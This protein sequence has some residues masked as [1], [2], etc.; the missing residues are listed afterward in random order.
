MDSNSL[1]WFYSYLQDR[2]QRVLINNSFSSLCNVSD[3]VSQGSVLS[4]L[5]F[6]LY[7]NDIAEKLIAPTSI[8]AYDTSFNYSNRDEL[9]IKPVIDHDMKELDEWSKIWLMYFNPD[10]TDIMIFQNSILLLMEELFLFQILT[11][12]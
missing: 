9:Q 1:N 11:N 8:F 10:K 12:I 4:T 6:I 2:Q 5:L 7:I 3:R